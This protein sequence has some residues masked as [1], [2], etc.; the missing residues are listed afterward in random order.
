MTPWTPSCRV[1]CC[2]LADLGSCWL[3]QESLEH[4]RYQANRSR[5]CL[6]KQVG[7]HVHLELHT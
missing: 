3:R 5:G 7:S 2:V 1:S 4:L 6:M